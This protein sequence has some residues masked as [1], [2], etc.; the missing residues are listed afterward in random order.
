VNAK[1]ALI[2]EK[3]F[4]EMRSFQYILCSYAFIPWSVLRPRATRWMDPDS[5]H[6]F[7]SASTS[8]QV[9]YLKE[10]TVMYSATKMRWTNLIYILVEYSS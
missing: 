6:A 8:K 7:I 4:L 2:W 3:R 10:H 9:Y 1:D 5:D